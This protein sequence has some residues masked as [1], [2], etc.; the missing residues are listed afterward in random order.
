MNGIKMSKSLGNVIDPFMLYSKYPKDAIRSY[1]LLEGP[2]TK[3]SDFD[4]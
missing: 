3:D 2:L 4:E 1:M